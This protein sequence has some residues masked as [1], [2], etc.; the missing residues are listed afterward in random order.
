MNKMHAGIR[1][2]LFIIMLF[3]AFAGFTACDKYSFI[4]PAVD[5]DYPWS[6][7]E[8]IQPIFN[9]NRCTECHRGG[10]PPDLREGQSYNTL[11]RGDYVTRPGEQSRLVNKLTADPDHA[12][13]VT[14]QDRLKIQYWIEQGAENN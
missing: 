12:I 7:S 4:P 10:V 2:V 9:N 8:D 5:P 3:T 11:T 1:Q 6:F 14:E 13:L